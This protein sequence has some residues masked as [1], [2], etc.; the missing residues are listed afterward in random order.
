MTQINYV[1]EDNQ[2]AAINISCLRREL[3]FSKKIL[4]LKTQYIYIRTNSY[5]MLLFCSYMAQPFQS[6]EAIVR[7]IHASMFD[8]FQNNIVCFLIHVGGV[9]FCEVSFFI[10]NQFFHLKQSINWISL[11]RTKIMFQHLFQ[12]NK[13]VVIEYLSKIHVLNTG[14]KYSCEKQKNIL[15]VRKKIK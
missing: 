14:C 7:L 4:V 5:E 3:H 13:A 9:V 11:I 2:L 10:N 8:T 6:I 12:N 15:T 1:I